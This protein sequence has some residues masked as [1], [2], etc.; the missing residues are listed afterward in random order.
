MMNRRGPNQSLVGTAERRLC[1]MFA[2][3]AFSQ[4]IAAL[5]QEAPKPSRPRA[6]DSSERLYQMGPVIAA[7]HEDVI[8][9]LQ[10]REDLLAQQE[11]RPPRDLYKEVEEGIFYLPQLDADCIGKSAVLP[12]ISQMESAIQSVLIGRGDS[13]AVQIDLLLGEYLNEWW[14]ISR[15]ISGPA[16]LWVDAAL[17]PPEMEV[18]NA[19]YR[20]VCKSGRDEYPHMTHEQFCLATQNFNQW[21]GDP[22]CRPPKA[23]LSLRRELLWVDLID[24]GLEESTVDE[25]LLQFDDYFAALPERRCPFSPSQHRRVVDECQRLEDRE[26]LGNRMPRNLFQEHA[27]GKFFAPELAM[28]ALITELAFGPRFDFGSGP[29]GQVQ[30]RPSP[31][32]QRD[33]MTALEAFLKELGLSKNI[34]REIL[35][36]R[37]RAWSEMPDR[38]P[39]ELSELLHKRPTAEELEVIINCY[40]KFM[41]GRKVP[42]KVIDAG[43]E[44]VEKYYEKRKYVPELQGKRTL[45]NR[46]DNYALMMALRGSFSKEEI[47]ARLE[48]FDREMSQTP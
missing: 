4:P 19:Q 21:L 32:I 34:T 16:H 9:Q 2:L 31:A 22:E 3:L 14:S 36:V 25:R 39:A 40:R 15:M 45:G 41:A 24:M 37:K 11:N 30:V 48:R 47:A 17:S 1:E 44:A 43:V 46:R 29:L 35:D 27:R 26:A 12:S 23:I 28:D 20:R 33:E 13:S 6:V 7:R 10:R 5:S 18:L 8:S 38:Y 42:A